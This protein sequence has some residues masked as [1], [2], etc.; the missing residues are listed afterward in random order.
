MGALCCVVTVRRNDAS[1]PLPSEKTC[2]EFGERNLVVM[3]F[4]SF[5]N[6]FL[7]DVMRNRELRVPLSQG[8]T[9]RRVALSALP[10][11]SFFRYSYS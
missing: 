8:L 9:K 2:G 4:F 6:F 10:G 7:S 3:F 1:R 11:V 5:G